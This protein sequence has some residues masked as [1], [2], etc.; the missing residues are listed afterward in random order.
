MAARA[1]HWGHL[2]C[3]ESGRAFSNEGPVLFQ[4]RPLTVWQDSPLFG[5]RYGVH[6]I[7]RALTKRTSCNEPFAAAGL[8]LRSSRLLRSNSSSSTVN[9]AFVHP[10]PVS[11]ER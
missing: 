5:K 10:K 8:T 6:A 9:T 2:F 11:F 3:A 4:Y 1:A 7:Y